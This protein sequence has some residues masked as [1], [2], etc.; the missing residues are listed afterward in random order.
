VGLGRISLESILFACRT[1]LALV[2]GLPADRILPIARRD[3][4]VPKLVG[5]Q[6]ILLRFRGFKADHQNHRD[7]HD[8]RLLH[9][10]HVTVR[11]RFEMDSPDKDTRWLTDAD[12]GNVPAWL[13]VLDGLQGFMPE[14]DDGNTTVEPLCVLEGD[15]GEKDAKDPGWGEAVL[16]F[17]VLVEAPLTLRQANSTGWLGNVL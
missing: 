9:R 6:D 7:R 4:D 2:T 10:L 11:T 17:G 8:C 14:D 3:Q 13:A 15:D 12:K 16:V 5:D 1:Q